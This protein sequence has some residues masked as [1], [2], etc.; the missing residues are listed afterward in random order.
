MILVIDPGTTQSAIVAIEDAQSM[1]PAHF[2]KDGNPIILNMVGAVG[3]G[4]VVVIEMMTSYGGKVGREVFDTLVWLGRFQQEA[5]RRGA[6]VHLINRVKVKAHICHKTTATDSQVRQALLAR[7]GEV[8]T[9]D[10]QGWFYGF[11]KD[12]WQAYALAVTYL[13]LYAQ[14]EQEG[15]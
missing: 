9:K 3:K 13:D 14:T 12:V 15:A 1:R 7:F 6:E 10:N 5:I 4:D 11:A 2:C 8:G